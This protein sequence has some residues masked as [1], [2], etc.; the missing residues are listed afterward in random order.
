ML[1]VIPVLL[2]A[3][4]ALLP[5]GEGSELCGDVGQCRAGGMKRSNKVLAPGKKR[6]KNWD[7][8]GVVSWWD[9]DE[10][11]MVALL[12]KIHGYRIWNLRPPQLVAGFARGLEVPRTSGNGE[13]LPAGFHR[14]NSKAE[15]VGGKTFPCSNLPARSR[16]KE[17]GVCSGCRRKTTASKATGFLCRSAKE[18]F[19][20][21]FSP[22]I[23]I[24]QAG[25]GAGGGRG[26]EIIL[27]GER[28]GIIIARPWAF[29][30]VFSPLFRGFWEQPADTVAIHGSA[31]GVWGAG[32]GN[33]SCTI[34][35]REK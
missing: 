31:G 19:P 18:S 34:W 5:L 11:G 20:P 9:W 29:L 15:S 14:K 4:N 12:P 8:C 2:P 27:A 13:K 28:E 35:S 33:N 30:E 16:R 25:K 17:C 6:R 32:D 3:G 23:F 21:L 22:Y 1:G 10:P 26:G 24:F 7:E